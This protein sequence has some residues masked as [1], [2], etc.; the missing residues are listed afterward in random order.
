MRQ[1]YR[2]VIPKV[3]HVA[4]P[5]ANKDKTISDRIRRLPMVKRAMVIADQIIRVH[6][7]DLTSSLNNVNKYVCTFIGTQSLSLLVN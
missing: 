5:R 1:T 6:I 7:D 2:N 4:D 3:H